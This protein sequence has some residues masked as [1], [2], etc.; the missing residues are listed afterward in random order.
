MVSGSECGCASTFEMTGMRGAVMFVDA[1]A[2]RSRSTAGCMKSV[3]KAPATASFT[4]IRA[5]TPTHSPD[6]CTEV[7]QYHRSRGGPAACASHVCL[8][9]LDMKRAL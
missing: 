2:P 8:S 6:T 3:W 5:C 1:S 4:V 9:V 7:K